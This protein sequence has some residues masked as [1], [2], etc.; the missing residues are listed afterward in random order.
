MLF[1]VY[2]IQSEQDSPFYVGHSHDVHLRL[3]HHNDGWTRSTKAKRP[4]KIVHVELAKSKGD[5]MKREREIKRMKSR[6]YIE[7][8]IDSL[9]LRW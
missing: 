1:Y 2:I 8:L 3:T 4:W 7:R 5:A 6:V 9:H